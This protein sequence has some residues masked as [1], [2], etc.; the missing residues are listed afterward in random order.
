MG[1]G[2]VLGM[3]LSPPSRIHIVTWS[4]AAV[5]SACGVRSSLTW[6]GDDVE[7]QGG[8][9]PSTG[10]TLDS[11]S[12]FVTATGAGGTPMP[13]SIAVGVGGA[14]LDTVVAASGVGGTGGAPS[15]ETVAASSTAGTSTTGTS[16]GSSTATSTAASSTAVTSTGA[17]G[18]GGGTPTADVACGSST[19][20]DGAVCCFSPQDSTKN[21]CADPGTCPM[22]TVSLACMGAGDCAMGERCCATFQQF[23]PG[24]EG[25]KGASC[26]ASCQVQQ[27]GQF[28]LV[29]CSD[30]QSTCPQGT[31]CEASQVLPVGFKVCAP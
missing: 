16:T 4:L 25:Y 31:S 19:C 28:G 1:G 6:L 15:P 17:T 22:G 13:D 8:A 20:T 23:G 26:K 14:P 7:G 12:G 2:K 24:P 30:E 21:V 3:T 9:A 18:A 11:G 5:V 29:L 27:F 10:S